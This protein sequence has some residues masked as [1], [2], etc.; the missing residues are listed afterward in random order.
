MTHIF[1]LYSEQI[2]TYKLSGQT[3]EELKDISASPEETA[4]KHLHFASRR[5]AGTIILFGA[6]DGLLGKALAENKKA[7]QELLICD[8]YPEHIR[9]L[10]QNELNQS[11]EDCTVLTD[12]SIWAMLLLLIQNGYSAASS[13]LILNP[14]LE[15]KSKNKHQNLQKIFSS[16]RNI[17]CPTQYST[18]RISAAAI[19]SPDEPELEDFI[20]SFPDWIAE[21]VLVWDCAESATA[22]DLQKFHRAEII[23]I[24]H[25]LDADFSTQRNRMIANCSG[26]WIIYLDADERLRP[27]NWD[28]IRLMTSCEKC[29][30]WYLPRMT[31][32]PDQNHCRIG[33]GLWPDLQLRLFKNN[34]N[35]R[36]VNKIHEQLTG[37]E[38][39]SGILPDTP[40]QHLTHLLKSRKKIESKLEKFNNLSEGHFS[41]RLGKEFPNIAKELLSPRKDRKVGP[42]LLPD[43]RMS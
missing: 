25:P 24:C 34:C 3:P 31:F 27:E 42:L 43:I 19:L 38:G 1:D 7:E 36:F 6:G 20:K 29:N 13:H 17:N 18:S 22:P 41:H 35:L 12:S 5:N 15:G 9:N 14:A 2:L 26:E 11:H 32:Y 10:R 37:L 33:Y 21:I 39:A 4:Q 16:C 28:D 23:N 40:I 8:L 30:G